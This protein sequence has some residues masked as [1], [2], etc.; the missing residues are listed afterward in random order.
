MKSLLIAATMIAF[1]GPAFAADIAITNGTGADYDEF[2]L[3]VP[4]E[5][6]STVNL[7][8]DAPT[9][10]FENGMTYTFKGLTEGT[11]DVHVY[12][13]E[14]PMSDC[15]LKAIDIKGAAVTLTPEML[16]ANCS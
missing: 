6:P 8:A 5:T 11:Y 14:D 12:D 15:T 2:Y 16:K 1:A 7:L 9:H 13:P 10:S 4:G 3:T